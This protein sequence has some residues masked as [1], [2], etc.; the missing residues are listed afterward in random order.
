MAINE[1]E[2]ANT[3]DPR[4]YYYIAVAYSKAGDAANAKNYA[5]KCAN[6]NSLINMNQAFVRNQANAMLSSM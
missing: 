4:T 3:Q 6:F 5:E 2:K 1:F